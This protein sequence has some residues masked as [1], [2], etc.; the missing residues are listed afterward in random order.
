MTTRPSPCCL[1]HDPRPRLDCR[2]PAA[3]RGPWSRVSGLDFLLLI[4]FIGRGSPSVCSASAAVVQLSGPSTFERNV[5]CPVESVC[6]AMRVV[7]VGGGPS[8]IVC[9]KTLLEASVDAVLLEAEQGLGGT[10]RARGYE[11]A[12]LVSSRQLTS[13]SDFRLPRDHPDHLSLPE[14]VDYL[15]AY[16]R[17]FG[18][19]DVKRRGAAWDGRGRIRLGAKVL[20]VRRGSGGKGHVVQ[21]RKDG[22]E[23][24]EEE[25]MLECDAVALCTG[26][27]VTPAVPAIPGFENIPERIHS[28][29][30]KGR[31]QLA[32]KKVLLL[33]CGETAMDI[34]Y[35]SVKAGAKEV[36]MCHRG[37]FL[38]L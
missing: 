14:Y 32:G 12:N 17:H 22:G 7:V 10:F 19:D 2:E 25:T 6:A 18:L 38:S 34:A 33:G 35:E 3:A 4:G 11:N 23:G 1:H 28:S 5:F 20:S 37:G 21:Y 15:E 13:F 16:A 27:H 9:L 30:Y 24:G 26:L 29:E 8:G 36:V 31:A